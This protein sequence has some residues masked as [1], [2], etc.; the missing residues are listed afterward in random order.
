MGLLRSGFFVVAVSCSLAVWAPPAQAQ[1]TISSG[2]TFLQ[3]VGTPFNTGSGNAN[4]FFG[5]TSAFATDMVFRDGWAYNQ[6][7]ATSNRPFSTLDTP[8]QT[9]VGNVATFTWANAGAGTAGFA[10]W[11]AVMTTTVTELGA[12][13]ARVD[14]TLVFKAN[15][16]NS[17]AI[18]F[19][20]FRQIDL[21]I[22]GTAVGN[23]LNDT[24]RVLDASS[25][26]GIYGRAFDSSASNYAD[27]IGLNAAR[28]EF[29]T[30]TALRSK[31]GDTSGTGSGSLATAAGTAVADWASTDG[32]VAFQWSP[33][34]AANQ[35]V[36]ISS[37]YTINAAL[38]PEPGTWALMLAGAAGVVALA[39]R[40]RRR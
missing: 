27:F 15:A 25:G 13:S 23:A 10:R 2:T 6:G 24:Y 33:T 37:S 17:A 7:V 1:G 11:D 38:V 32:A 20:I 5:S 29:N 34:L 30:G 9:Y 39:T 8:V 18:A 4:L 21:D 40:R 3:F 12:S 16:G 35:S 36:T 26:S 14:T 28:Y 22:I 31:L 19:N